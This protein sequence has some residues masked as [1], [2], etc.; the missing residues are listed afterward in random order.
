VVRAQAGDLDARSELIETLQPSVGKIARQYRRA[1]TIEQCELMQEGVVGLLRALRRYDPGFGTP[2]WAYAS[3]WVRQAMQRLVSELARPVVLSDRGARQLARVRAEQR[4]HLQSHGKE[5]T[6]EHLARE[7]GLPDKQI[8]NLLATERY[9]HPVGEPVEDGPSFGEQI[10]DPRVDEEYERLPDRI[11]LE[12]MSLPLDRLTRRER[13]IL[14][15]RFGFGP[16]QYTLAELGNKLGL[17]AERVRQ[18]E[19][20]ALRKLREAIGEETISFEGA[21]VLH[22][23]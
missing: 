10:A 9:P 22:S 8:G 4:R 2:F 15:G 7:T 17:S 14:S 21:A 3:W 13:L 5:P 12:Q 1:G 23:P 16:T 20:A 11:E 6:L 18:I 19:Q